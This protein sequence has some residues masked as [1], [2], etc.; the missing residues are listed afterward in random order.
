MAIKSKCYNEIETC[1][2]FHLEV[3][4]FEG[5]TNLFHRKIDQ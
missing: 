5:N 2:N 3:I 1:G 4:N